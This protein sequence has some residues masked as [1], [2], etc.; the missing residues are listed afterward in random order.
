MS[1]G[2]GEGSEGQ[3]EKSADKET[4]VFGI[5]DYIAIAIAALET[6]LLPFVILMIVIA[7][8]ALFF[9]FRP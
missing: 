4:L 6:F 2:E 5:R 3:E 9:E 8:V 1:E 7:A